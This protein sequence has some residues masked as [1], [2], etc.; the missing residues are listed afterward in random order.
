MKC[1]LNVYITGIQF[2]KYTTAKLKEMPIQTLYVKVK[3]RMITENQ[4]CDRVDVS[5]TY[6]YLGLRF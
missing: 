3:F 1:V 2:E 5:E 4:S 6:V